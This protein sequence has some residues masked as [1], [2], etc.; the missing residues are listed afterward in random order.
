MTARQGDET[1]ALYP[2]G[3]GE[4]RLVRGLVANG[5]TAGW[6]ADS[7]SLFVQTLNRDWPIHVFRFNVETGRR[8]PWKDRKPSD[9]AG[10]ESPKGTN[11]VRITPDGRFLMCS[12]SSAVFGALRGGSRAR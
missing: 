1:L 2:V 5:R 8:E 10:V 11:G 7:R 3:S 4:P 12:A 6:S 9:A